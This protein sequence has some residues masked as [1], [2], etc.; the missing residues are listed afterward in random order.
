MS[1]QTELAQVADTITVNSGKIRIGESDPDTS[2]DVVGGS[3]DSVIDTLTLKNDNIGAS[4][5]T[6]IN[7]VVD[8]V[9][10][11]TTA[12]IY[13]Q[14]TG[15]AYHQGSLQFLT[16]DNSGGGLTERMR[17]DSAGRVTKPY[18][19][20]FF[21]S[22][23]QGFQTTASGATIVLDTATFNVGSHY[24]TSTGRFTAPVTGKYFVSFISYT[25]STG[26]LTLKKNGSDF[27]VTDVAF[28]YLPN[29][30]SATSGGISGLI[31]LNAN[32]YIHFGARNNQ[33][34]YY[35]QGHTTFSAFLIG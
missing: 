33:Q 3:A 18:Q 22:G 7:F 23:N 17:I 10:D 29:S 31:H 4:A 9:N 25:Q 13:G 14:R 19:P 24:S 21:A 35:Y 12:A 11:I 2:L 27:T 5:G 32:D 16:K 1:K 28:L 6:G 34:V 26:T 30:V 15:A 20:S 8:G